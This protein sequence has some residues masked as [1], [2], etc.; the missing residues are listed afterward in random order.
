MN[1]ELRQ[2]LCA[3]LLESLIDFWKASFFL[4][5]ASLLVLTCCIIVGIQNHN[6]E[7]V[8][9]FFLLYFTFG[10]AVFVTPA[11]LH[12]MSHEPTRVIFKWNEGTNT[13]FELAEFLAF[14][15]FFH[16]C[17]KT[18][19]FRKAS[20]IFLIVLSFMI[21]CF[22]ISFFSNDYT[23]DKIEKHSFYI[24]AVELLFLAAMCLGYIYELFSTIPKTNLFQRPS[25]FIV[26]ISFFY[27]VLMIPFFAMAEDMFK[28]GRRVSLLLFD[29]HFLLLIILLLTILRTFF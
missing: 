14:Y 28:A 9:L 21:A 13:A 3:D 18:P 11:L 29:C 4:Q 8:R 1:Q 10:M 26:V 27:A 7:R 15:S 24:N 2:T 12:L 17:L 20:N 23:S 19:K 5:P 16:K 22:F 6:G 25:F